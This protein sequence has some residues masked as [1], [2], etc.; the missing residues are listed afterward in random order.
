MAVAERKMCS[1]HGRAGIGIGICN[2]RK[3]REEELLLWAGLGPRLGSGA[4]LRMRLRVEC[5]GVAVT[6]PIVADL[7]V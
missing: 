5:Q 7:I 6:A 3:A 4:G 2:Q 1:L